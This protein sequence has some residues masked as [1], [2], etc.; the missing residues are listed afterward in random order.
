M[1]LGQSQ[2]V[3]TFFVAGAQLTPFRRL[4][5]I[6]LELRTIEDSLKKSD[7]QRRRTELKIAKL[8]PG[9]P[10]EAID[11]EE[12]QWDLEQQKQLIADAESRR[13]NFLLLK[14]DL[15]ES[16]P[17]EYWDRGF[18]AAECDHWV[19]YLTKQLTISQV[20]GAPDRTAMEQLMLMPP[21]AQ[22]RVMIGVAKSTQ[23]LQ[24]R[25]QEVLQLSVDAEID[26][27]LK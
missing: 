25:N 5:Q 4:R 15:L 9:I 27:D 20:L 3:D 23:Q 16:V 10:E 24:L 22:D 13:D 18:E 17:Q 19:A 7:F 26:P 12:A 8:S 6:E 14:K 11:L 2:F 1:N 21:E